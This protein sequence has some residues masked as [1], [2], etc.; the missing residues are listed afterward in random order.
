MVTESVPLLR[1][2]PIAK[3]RSE[4]HIACPPYNHK[5]LPI[6][7]RESVWAPLQVPGMFCN[8]EWQQLIE[9]FQLSIQQNI[10]HPVYG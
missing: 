2:T 4:L 7:T 1:A 5:H 8:P 3:F 6:G 10:H 9:E